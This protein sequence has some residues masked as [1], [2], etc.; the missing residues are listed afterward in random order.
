MVATKKPLNP[1]L[2]EY[3]ALAYCLLAI[4]LGQPMLGNTQEN[5]P[6]LETIMVIG[7]RIPR[8]EPQ[9]GSVTVIDE[10]AIRERND[11][12]IFDLLRDVPGV[13]TSLPG[14]QGSL[15]SVFIRGSEPNYGAILVD[16]V[17]VNNPTNT[18]GGSFD[19]SSLDINSIERI[20]VLRAPQSSIY[21]SNALSGVINLI[22]HSGSE[23]LTANTDVELGS[24][25]YF[26][27]G[28]QL[29]GPAPRGG[30]YNIRLDNTTEHDSAE[31]KNRSFTSKFT[32]E[33]GGL[34]NFSIHARHSLTDSKAFPDDS[35]GSRLAVLREKSRREAQGTS[36]GFDVESTIT[37]RTS[38]HIS[39][40]L[41]EH[42]EQAFS[43]AVI[44]GVR[45]GIPENTSDT[46]FSRGTLNVFLSSGVTDSVHTVYGI[47]YQEESGSGT[48]LIQLEPL[49]MLP[50]SYQLDRNN[51]SAYGEINYTVSQNFTLGAALRI[52][53][54]DSAGIVH[55]GKI[56]LGYTLP[57]HPTRLHL[58]WGEGFK[59]PSLY[60]LGDPLVGNPTLEP[61]TADSWE[62]GMHS[63]QMNGRLKW[64]VS[65]FDQR[66]SNLIDFDAPSFMIINRPQVNTRGLEI[67]A[68]FQA[69]GDWLLSTHATHLN[70]NTHDANIQLRH[71][72]ENIGGL[73]LEWAPSEIWKNFLRAY[74]VGHRFDSSVPTGGQ[75][76][77]S[78]HS[79]DLV[80]RR[81]LRQNITLSFS[82]DN[83]TN[84][85]FEPVIGFPNLGRRLRF[86]IRGS[87]RRLNGT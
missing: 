34:L 69:S 77:P 23:V 10:Q 62:L 15:G 33:I 22:T 13:H 45:S 46:D 26:H 1:V 2:S 76:L 29:G 78:Y 81:N 41:F 51:L 56:S 49:F 80:V 67:S 73:R 32:S 65:A 57:N 24:H 79:V 19:F 84:E 3:C 61:E 47:E 14:G 54:A 68:T 39:G 48:S 42:A 87:F 63:A 74:Y 16:G 86:S 66:F 8:T 27:A 7:T 82:I 36:L 83:L 11:S 35:G 9:V 6:A 40:S 4:G 38:L 17:Q 18:R 25:D 28:I 50:T 58:T 72:P 85:S 21:G 43:P 60:S 52:D 64:E 75:T 30:I 20:E 55:T 37:N 44:S 5:I 59:L 71:R 12:S 70:I 53:D 31:F